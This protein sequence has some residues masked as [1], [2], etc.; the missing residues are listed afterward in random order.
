MRLDIDR[1]I[2]APP[3]M[4]WDALDTPATLA[5]CLSGV[6]KLEKK[7][8]LFTIEATATLGPM[9]THVSGE[10]RVEDVEKPT[11]RRLVGT[12]ESPLGFVKGN[13]DIKLAAKTGED[14][15]AGTQIQASIDW[16][17]GGKMAQMGARLIEPL[18]RQH[19]EDFLDELKSRLE[20]E[21]ESST[22][23][24]DMPTETSSQPLPGLSPWVWGGGTLLAVVIL[25]IFLLA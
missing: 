20:A 13:A 12:G 24:P 11:H 17:V 3:E 25:L 1:W 15:R 14:G 21:E 6:Q 19:A 10:I 23:L 22:L 7:D 2:A 8:A 9:Q 4:V 18:A 16:T 5:H